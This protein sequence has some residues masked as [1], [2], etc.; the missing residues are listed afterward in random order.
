MAIIVGIGAQ[1]IACWVALWRIEYVPRSY[2]FALQISVE[3]I[4]PDVSASSPD[5]L[6]CVIIAISA[7]AQKAAFVGA[8]AAVVKPVAIL[9]ST[10]DNNIIHICIYCGQFVSF[11]IICVLNIMQS[12]ECNY[13]ET[14]DIRTSNKNAKCSRIILHAIWVCV[15]AHPHEWIGQFAECCQPREQLIYSAALST[16]NQCKT[17]IPHLMSLVGRD[18]GDYSM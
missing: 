11:Q 6:E 12:L 4:H 3:L 9:M 17:I 2:T 7:T 18:L 1:Q 14:F 8:C 16:L 13:C 15:S 10:L 5:K